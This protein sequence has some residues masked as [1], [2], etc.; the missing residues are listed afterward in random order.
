VIQNDK[1]AQAAYAIAKANLGKREATGRNDGVFVRMI[2]N[3]LDGAGSWMDGQ[4]WCAAF[5]TWCV[6][7]AAASLG[8]R[9]YLRR[10]GSSTSIYAQ[11]KKDGFLLSGPIPFCIGLM[12]GSGGTRGKTHH[13]TFIVAEV[14]YPAGIVRGIDGNWRNAV[15]RST[16]KIAECDFV[17]IC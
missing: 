12:R 3:W 2:Q 16:H 15:S 13:H 14:D 6:W 17:A 5:A 1:L 11:A 10:N 9:P 7:Q 8:I 4:P